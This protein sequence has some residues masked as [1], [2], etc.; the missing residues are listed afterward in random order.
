MRVCV[1]PRASR[2]RLTEVYL[3]YDYDYDYYQLYQLSNLGRT[4]KKEILHPL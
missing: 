3:H 4:K 2:N 1:Y